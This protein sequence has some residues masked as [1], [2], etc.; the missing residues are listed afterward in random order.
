MKDEDIFYPRLF[1]LR[2]SEMYLI[3][4]NSVNNYVS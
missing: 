3:F 2:I 4:I 1:Y